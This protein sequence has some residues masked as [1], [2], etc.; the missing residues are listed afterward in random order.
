MVLSVDVPDK[1]VITPRMH[2]IYA[3]SDVLSRL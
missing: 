2:R 3:F 1:F